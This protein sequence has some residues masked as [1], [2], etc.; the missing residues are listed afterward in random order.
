M[1]T[2][3]TVPL[4]LLLVEDE[5]DDAELLYLELQ[6]G[7]FEVSPHRVQTEPE[8][9]SALHE[10]GWDIIISD[11]SMPT[12]SGLR[13]F[14]IYSQRGI[15]TP[16]I[17]VSG[18]LG[19]ERAVRAM[20][21]GA[22]DYLLKGQLGRLCAAVQRELQGRVDR[23][24]QR[25]AE[26][27]RAQEQRRLS[28]AVEASRTAVFE[29]HLPP[30]EDSFVSPRLAEI[31]GYVPRDLPPAGQLL[32]WLQPLLHPDDRAEWEE[33]TRAFVATPS[34][35]LRLECRVQDRAEG[36]KHLLV[37]AD[38]ERG[39]DGRAQ[40]VAGV[41][42][43]QTKEKEAEAQ[44]RSVEKAE[45]VGRFASGVAHDF[46]NMLNV[47]LG[48]TSL[49]LMSTDD[50]HPATRSLHFIEEAGRRAERLANELMT[51]GASQD[52]RPETVVVGRALSGLEG[53]I[54]PARREG[55]EIEFVA[56]ETRTVRI[57]AHH[58]EQAV[59]NLAVNACDA[60]PSGGRLTI[61]VSD[62]SLTSREARSLGLDPAPHVSIRVRDTGTGIDPETLPRIFEPFFSTKGP[63]EG[64]GL[65]LAGVD[66]FVRQSGGRVRVKSKLGQGTTF[67]VILPASS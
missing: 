62:R 64:T 4:R 43:D 3:K 30:T 21:A 18:A 28:L 9:Q 14:E 63:R 56:R 57:D 46:N 1:R 24:R 32:T 50:D 19:E 53:L 49:A 26:S 54:P 10:K 42:L 61:E 29:L 38:A 2:K 55:V 5:P 41:V 45:A 25:A 20:R 22:K 27:A 17:F 39:E 60:M 15:D 48:H 52:M 67:E 12:F 37:L 6:G 59:V 65:G 34:G 8:F 66:G 44:L 33:A 16:F 23:E 35:R 51:F 7:G 47:I 40:L 13:A 36:W 11:F 58:L 31:L